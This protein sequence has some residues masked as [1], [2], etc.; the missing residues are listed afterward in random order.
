MPAQVHERDILQGM[1]TADHTDIVRYVSVEASL[2][3]RQLTRGLNS[4]RL[5]ALQLLGQA[6]AVAVQDAVAVFRQGHLSHQRLLVRI[7]SPGG[8]RIA[9]F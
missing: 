1:Q 3:A 4:M 5:E 9:R 2:S 6:A 7:S 8:L